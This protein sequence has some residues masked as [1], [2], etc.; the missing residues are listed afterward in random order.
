MKYVLAV[1][2]ATC[3]AFGVARAQNRIA[4]D[5]IV[6]S[7]QGDDEMQYVELRMLAAAQNGI[8]NVW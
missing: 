3:A 1:V 6:G 4:L 7:W 2:V 8:A 5:E